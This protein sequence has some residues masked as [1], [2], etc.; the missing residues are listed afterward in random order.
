MGHGGGLTSAG[1]WVRPINCDGAPAAAIFGVKATAV[2][3]PSGTTRCALLAS[4]TDGDCSYVVASTRFVARDGARVSASG[5]G[6]GASLR[7]AAR[8]AG[9]DPVRGASWASLAAALESTT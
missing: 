7:R 9:R 8:G 6:R 4:A 1:G 2:S 3:K 5:K